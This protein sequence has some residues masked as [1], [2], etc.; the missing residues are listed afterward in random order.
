MYYNK[1]MKDW[2]DWKIKRVDFGDDI[3]PVSLKKV[4]PKVKRFFYRGKWDKELFSKAIAVV[5]SRK[6]TKY[7]E[8]ATKLLVKGLVEAGYTIVSGF[9]YGVDTAA[10]KACLESGGKTVVVFGCG[11]DK[12]T[13]AENDKLYGNILD[14]GGVVISEYEKDQLAKYWTFPE[15]NRIVAGLSQAVLVIEGGIK[16]G[17]LITAKLGFGQKKSV[18][19]VPGQIG[20]SQSKGT[21][22]LIRNGAVLVSGVEDIL[23]EL[24]EINRVKRKSRFLPKLSEEE[25][26]VMEELER[27]NLD[28]DELARR[29]EWDIVK[30]GGRLSEMSLKGVVEEVSG[31]YM[32]GLDY[33]D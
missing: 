22:W 16:S 33:V 15:R 29:L 11:L 30:V 3:Y 23:E 5:G 14:S 13:P 24:G 10:H 1:L 20:A 21:N 12:I 2:R 25:K 4:K 8:M 32:I 19:A 17:S 7:G 28:A 27:E 6:M 9:M 31:V 26:K 18:L